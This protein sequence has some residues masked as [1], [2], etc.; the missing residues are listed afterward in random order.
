MPNANPSTPRL[1]HP[2]ALEAAVLSRGS[3][4]GWMHRLRT[5]GLGRTG[6]LIDLQELS[7]VKCYQLGQGLLYLGATAAG[8]A[9]ML[10]RVMA[11]AVV[12]RKHRPWPS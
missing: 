7:F 4:R 9:A 5:G 1:W 11:S 2:Q 3:V 8:I 10:L 12:L 6:Q